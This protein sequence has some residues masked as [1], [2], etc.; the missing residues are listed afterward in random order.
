MLR[1]QKKYK[2]RYHVVGKVK[3]NL[4]PGQTISFTSYPAS[5][6]SQD[7]FYQIFLDDG[8][9]VTVTGTAL[10]FKLDK[11]KQGDEEPVSGST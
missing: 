5:I 2:L 6:H 1:I 3:S 7:D 11:I 4:V 9:R 8:S 10:N